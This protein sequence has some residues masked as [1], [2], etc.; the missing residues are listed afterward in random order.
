MTKGDLR[1]SPFS[2]QLLGLSSVLLVLCTSAFAQTEGDASDLARAVQNPVASLISVPFQTNTNMGWGADEEIRS[3]LNIQPVIPLKLSED[4]NLITR[5]IASVA[6]QPVLAGGDRKTGLGDT[7]FTAFL[8]PTDS[9]KIIW[10]AGPVLL[11]PTATDNILGSDQWG[12][13]PSIVVLTMPGS[14]VIGSLIS[15]VWSVAGSGDRD[16]NL[17]TW[18][19]FVN[20]NMQGGWY[21]TSSPIITANWEASEDEWTIPLG[22]GIGRVFHVGKQAMNVQAQGFYNV[23]KPGFQGDW[24]MRLQVQF[25]FPK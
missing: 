11:M 18:Q 1:R 23:E 17:F 6:T 14:W 12:L 19:Y 10:G 24:S 2:L 21:L 22:G 13:G 8:S 4:W 5:T 7:T 9:G 25:M 3:V 20:Y 16:V 15:N